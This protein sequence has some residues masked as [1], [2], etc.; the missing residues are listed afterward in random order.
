VQ[1]NAHGQHVF[2]PCYFT[3]WLNND[4]R[5]GFIF[6]QGPEAEGDQS[7][8]L[9]IYTQP[10]PAAGLPVLGNVLRGNRLADR[11]R[12]GLLHYGPAL[13]AQA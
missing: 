6:E 13:M 4:L 5:E 2:P 10:L 9:G 3:Q 8:V 7:A 11:S 12:I 1:Y